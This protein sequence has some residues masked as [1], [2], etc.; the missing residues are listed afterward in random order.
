MLLARLYKARRQL[1]AELVKELGRVELF[2][3]IDAGDTCR[4]R[5]GA[6]PVAARKGDAANNILQGFTAAQGGHVVAIGQRLAEANQVSL[7]A[8]IMVGT[9][10]IHAEARAHVVNNEHNAVVVA[11][12]AHL[13]PIASSGKKCRS[14]LPCI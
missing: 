8:K 12:L 5:H 1:A 4:K 7:E 9:C 6:H 14:K 3:L 11:K 13:L 10:K 2:H